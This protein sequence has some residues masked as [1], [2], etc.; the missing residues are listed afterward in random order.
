M[1]SGRAAI[2]IGPPFDSLNSFPIQSSLQDFI[3]LQLISGDIPRTPHTGESSGGWK[4]VKPVGKEGKAAPPFP[5]V[6]RE[7]PPSFFLM[8]SGNGMNEGRE[9]SEIEW[10]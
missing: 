3:S 1:N 2:T 5:F 8:F 6:P 9:E 7:N 4:L 10:N